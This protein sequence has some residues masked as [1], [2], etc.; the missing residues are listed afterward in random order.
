MIKE[1]IQLANH[2]DS[3]GF[4]VEANYLDSIIRTASMGRISPDE[5]SEEEDLS[6]ETSEEMEKGRRYRADSPEEILL[7]RI[8]ISKILRDMYP[9]S[10]HEEIADVISEGDEAVRK[11]VIEILSSSFYS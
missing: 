3:K 8:H 9:D 2:L 10:S 4:V 7:Q 6:R 11:R 1:L 5:I